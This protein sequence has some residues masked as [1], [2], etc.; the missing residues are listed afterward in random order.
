MPKLGYSVKGRKNLTEYPKPFI[1]GG[2]DRL[3][4]PGGHNYDL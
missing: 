3:S 4:N 1:V 2:V